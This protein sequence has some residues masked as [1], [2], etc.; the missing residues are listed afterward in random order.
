LIV[1]GPIKPD[2]NKGD[3]SVYWDVV[4]KVN[5]PLVREEKEVIIN[6]A[7]LLFRSNIINDFSPEKAAE[8][9]QVGYSWFRK[10]FK[11]YTGLSPGQYYI[12]LKIERAKELLNN[13]E[14]PIKEIAYDLRFDSYFYF[15]RI[16]KEKTG[17]SPTDYRKRAILTV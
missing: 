10:V 3:C 6:K 15:S 14:I 9:L 5:L 11:N 7:R 13:S 1:T 2:G 12:Q 16:F 4:V 17:L 8:E